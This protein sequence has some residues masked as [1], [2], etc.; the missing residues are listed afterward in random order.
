MSFKYKLNVSDRTEK[1]QERIE[2]KKKEQEKYDWEN[3]NPPELD[4]VVENEDSIIRNM[5][6]SLR[7][8]RES[9]NQ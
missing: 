1:L 5:F 6:D 4:V 3:E 9:M 7:S 2:G 8:T